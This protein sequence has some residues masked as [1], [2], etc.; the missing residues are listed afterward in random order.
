MR[1]NDKN[2]SDIFQLAKDMYLDSDYYSKALHQEQLLDFIKRQDPKK[3]EK[4]LKLSLLSFPDDVFVFKASYILNPFMS[5]RIKGFCFANYEELG[6]TM[7]SYSPTPNP[8][9]TLLVRY[10]LLSEHMRITYYKHDHQE[11]YE[12][13]LAL[14]KL[15]EKDLPYSYYMIGY[16]LSKSTSIYYR[17]IEYKDIFNLTYFLCKQEKDLESLGEYLSKSPLL[18]AYG[19][20]AKETTP[21]QTY[22]HLCHE[23]DRSE[24]LLKEFLNKR[25]NELKNN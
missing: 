22:L 6:K 25:K 17:G 11:D 13:M 19:H 9:L 7:L 15:S 3:H 18:R 4:I 5:L 20:Y 12:K 8:V 1:F 16:F 23:A 10:A 2:Y 14:E 21:I 24:D